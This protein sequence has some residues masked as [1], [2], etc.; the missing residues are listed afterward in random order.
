M[1]NFTIKVMR[2]KIIIVI[3]LTGT[4]LVLA[5]LLFRP[6]GDQKS[7]ENSASIKPKALTTI[8]SE[9]KKQTNEE[10]GIRFEYPANY[11]LTESIA[12]SLYGSTEAVAYTF[13]DTTRPY[14]APVKLSFYK[15]L[16]IK[17]I[18]ELVSILKID[19]PNITTQTCKPQKQN[20][21][22]VALL[23]KEGEPQPP[24]HFIKQYD[25]GLTATTMDFPEKDTVLYDD[26]D[27]NGVSLDDPLAK[28]FSTL[29]RTE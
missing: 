21:I 26:Y 7:K 23:T 15:I 29:E 12:T 9:T 28:V 2:A 11:E 25:F 27:Q 24:F 6:S 13:T 10:F 16:E 20:T 14:I 22:C 4:I 3:V 18:E 5:F 1:Y 19:F 8:T 17:T